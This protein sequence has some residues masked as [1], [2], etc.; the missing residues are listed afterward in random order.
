MFKA[1]MKKASVFKKIIESKKDFTP[2]GNVDILPT[3][4][5]FQVFDQIRISMVSL[6]M[7][8]IG[9]DEYDV[10]FP[11]VIGVN[12]NDLS[13][14]MKM[15]PGEDSLT[16]KVYDNTNFLYII[17]ENEN[18]TESTTFKLALY[19]IDADRISCDNFES[20]AIVTIPS[21][22]FVQ[23]INRHEKISDSSKHY[24]LIYSCNWNY[25]RQY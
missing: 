6:Q 16:L 22:K 5:F 4:I 1:K 3:G 17:F 11:L 8:A 14:V 15:F 18:C 23:I 2:I 21:A 10:E 19:N 7:D 13:L 25:K 24:Y 12:F 20:D 9:F